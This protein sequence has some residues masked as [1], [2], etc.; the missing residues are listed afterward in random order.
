[1]VVESCRRGVGRFGAGRPNSEAAT[2]S[3]VR[4]GDQPQSNGSSFGSTGG[5]QSTWPM[6]GSSFP[7]RKQRP[8]DSIVAT[9]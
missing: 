4:R 3:R 9:S 8:R 7:L 5:G 2:S 6:R 1:M